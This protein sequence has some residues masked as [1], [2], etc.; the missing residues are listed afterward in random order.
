MNADAELERLAQVG[1]KLMIQV[2][3]IR[4]DECG[5]AH[6]LPAGGNRVDVEPEKRKQP[7]ADELIGL[8]AGID[9]CLRGCAEKPVN[10][11]DHVERQP[12]L[13]EL[14]GTPHIHEHADDITLS[15]DVDALPIAHKI[16]ANIRRQQWDNRDIGVWS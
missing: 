11:E 16:R 9:H 5:R 13:G 12:R 8:A 2:F 15:A 7:I 1:G 3:N 10:Q 4:G 6:R 14:G